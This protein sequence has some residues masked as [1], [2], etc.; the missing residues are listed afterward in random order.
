MSNK[1]NLF[2]INPNKFLENCLPL[3]YSILS[4]FHLKNTYVLSIKNTFE[5][6]F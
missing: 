2:M 6:V 4:N 5:I 1:I 3:V